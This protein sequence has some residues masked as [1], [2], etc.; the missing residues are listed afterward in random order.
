[1]DKSYDTRSKAS[2]GKEIK[3]G[4]QRPEDNH[5][6][7]TD[8]S[9][10]AQDQLTSGQPEHPHVKFAD[11]RAPKYM[12]TETSESRTPGSETLQSGNTL[13][14]TPLGRGRGRG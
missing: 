5:P 3:E 11:E 1:M 10:S 2:R 9:T 7:T 13:S 6:V 14:T 12:E 8:L 4:K